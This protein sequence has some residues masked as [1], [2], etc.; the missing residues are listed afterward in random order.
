MNKKKIIIFNIMI[1]LLLNACSAVKMDLQNEVF[2]AQ[3]KNGIRSGRAVKGAADILKIKIHQAEIEYFNLITKGGR[4][5]REKAAQLL[6]DIKRFKYT[7]NSLSE[8]ENHYNSSRN[9]KAK[10]TK[11]SFDHA[12]EKYKKTRK[13]TG[14]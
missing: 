12:W 2:R 3:N 8:S 5:N 4:K 7:L 1:L 11:N 13:I 6:E 9:K 14:Y 10:T